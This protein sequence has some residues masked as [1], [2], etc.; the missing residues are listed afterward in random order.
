M[1][2]I[3]RFGAA[4]FEKKIVYAFPY[5]AICKGLSPWGGAI[6]DPRDFI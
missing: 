1:L 4:V 2:N 6:N 3:I 5:I